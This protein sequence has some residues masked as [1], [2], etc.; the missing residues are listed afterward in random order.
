M[1]LALCVRLIVRPNGTHSPAENMRLVSAVYWLRDGF[2]KLCLLESKL[3]LQLVKSTEHVRASNG[4]AAAVEAL[5]LLQDRGRGNCRLQ[6]VGITRASAKRSV[7]PE[8]RCR[9]EFIVTTIEKTFGQHSNGA[10]KVHR[11]NMHYTL[12]FMP[13]S[14]RCEENKNVT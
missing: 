9:D 8:K 7:L 2:A 1:C 12:L 11:A 14:F 3:G 5:C 6:G 10:T 13:R 4:A